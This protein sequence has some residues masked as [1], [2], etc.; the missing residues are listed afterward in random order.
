MP[1]CSF[2]VA[3]INY[4]H[5]CDYALSVAYA[6]S[7]C[8]QFAAFGLNENEDSIMCWIWEH[9]A[10]GICK[11]SEA[12]AIDTECIEGLSARLGLC[13]ITW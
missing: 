12:A 3:S 13:L 1:K 5:S 6:P 9:C 10:A 7:N 8:V 2:V 4:F 11:P